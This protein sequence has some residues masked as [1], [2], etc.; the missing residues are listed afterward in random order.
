MKK[1]DVGSLK[2]G[3]VGSLV[4]YSKSSLYFLVLQP[5]RTL[6][7]CG[8]FLITAKTQRKDTNA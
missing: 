6:R 1:G 4:T 8:E 2:K 5:L 3:D 7:L